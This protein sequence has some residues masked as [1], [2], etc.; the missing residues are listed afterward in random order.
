MPARTRSAR[1]ARSR[2][3]SSTTRPRAWAFE[4]LESRTL[5]SASVLTDLVN[6]NP[7]G[8][9]IITAGGFQSGET[10]QFQV[11]HTDGTINTGP[12][13]AAWQV[14]DTSG[15]GN[16]QT[17]WNLDPT[18]TGSFEVVAVGQTSASVATTVFSD[19]G[20]YPTP[21][22]PSAATV[23]PDQT[24]YTAPTTALINAGG[25]QPGESVKFQVLHT[26]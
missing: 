22:A 14:T 18:D 2:S 15:T 17:S 4:Q 24:D 9:A 7:A 8:T 12:N 5:L 10:V 3:K 11:L 25:F 20:A 21:I 16:I 19:S 1:R 6:Y 23:A 13:E 26:D